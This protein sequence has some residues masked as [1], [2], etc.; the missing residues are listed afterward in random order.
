MGT[1]PAP[2]RAPLAKAAF[3]PR[4]TSGLAF[5]YVS[6]SLKALPLEEL[7]F[8]TLV[9]KIAAYNAHTEYLHLQTRDIRQTSGK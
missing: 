3:A 2:W 7:L 8:E 9:D 4:D 6:G 5:N 1:V